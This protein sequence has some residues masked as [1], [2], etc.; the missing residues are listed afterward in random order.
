MAKR[1]PAPVTRTRRSGGIPAPQ[2]SD[3][4][5]DYNPFLKASDI[6]DV[7]DAATLLLTGKVRVADSGFG[8]QM[9]C[10]VRHNGTIYDWGFKIDGVNHRIL[11]KR[12]GATENAWRGK[13]NVTI[14]TFNGNP[15]IA[16]D[17]E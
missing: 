15:Y 10:E 7:D 4:T 17:R 3:K 5:S 12:F 14:K 6:G 8:E 2:K 11:F 16:A 1:K 9:I 13:V